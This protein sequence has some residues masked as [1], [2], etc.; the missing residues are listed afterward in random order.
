MDSIKFLTVM[1]IVAIHADAMEMADQAP[2][3]LVRADLLESA[4]AHAKQVAWYTGAGI[5]EVV[6]HLTTRV[7]LAHAFVDGNKRTASYAGLQFAATNGG[8]DPSPREM[9]A[10]A[11]HLIAYIEADP[12][13]REAAFAEFVAF[14]EQ[15]F[16]V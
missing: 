12:A 1:D 2:A 5:P 11:D 6:V 7:A 15:W 3:A 13:D 9:I 4:A 14:V 8:R 16:Q 10:F